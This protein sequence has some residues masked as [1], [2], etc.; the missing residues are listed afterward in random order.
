MRSRTI[1]GHCRIKTRGLVNVGLNIGNCPGYLGDA[2]G[3]TG[4]NSPTRILVEEVNPPA[5]PSKISEERKG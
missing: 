4:W 1:T 5:P 2:D 3:Y